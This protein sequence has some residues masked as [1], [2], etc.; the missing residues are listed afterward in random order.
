MFKPQLI[1]SLKNYDGKT[2][3][4]DLIAGI[5][6]GI[7]ALPLAIAFA[8]ASGVNPAAGLFTAIIAGFCI[9][10]FGGSTVQI[11]GP[12]GAFAVIV[13]GV[14]SE[15]GF[16]GLATATLMAGILLILLGAFKMGGLVKFIPYTIVTGFTA[17]IALTIASGQI[18]DF[19]G[20]RPDFSSPMTILG[21]QYSKMPGDFLPKIIVYAKSFGTLNI[22]TTIMAAVSLVFIFVWSKFVKK[23]PGSFIVIIGATIASFLL[24]KFFGLKTDTIGFFADGTKHFEIPSSLP[25]PHLPN[26]NIE[27]IRILFPTSASIAV[28]AA[29][30][31][32]LSA[33]VADGMTGKKHDSNTEL[34][35]QGIA[36][37][38]SPLFG[39]IPATG[40]IART[41]TNIKNGGKTP[42]AG[43]IHSI[44]LLLIL[45][46]FGKYASY[47]PMAA[48]A[49]VLINVAWNMAGFP[50]I[51]ALCHG[52][53]SDICVLAVT[54]LITVFIDLTAA[55]EVGLGFA[56]F[57][58]I[59]KM[60]DL[61]EVENKRENLISGIDSNPDIPGEHIDVPKG[62]VVYEIDG[63]LF[64]GTVRKFEVA[65]ERAG[66]AGIEYKVLILRMRNTLYLDAGG[67]RA[68]EQAKAAC[69]RKGVT[70]VI[71]GIH[72]QP[73]ILL[74][75]TGMAEK[76]GHENIHKNIM[77]AL[78]RAKE[79]LALKKE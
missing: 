58:F 10:A 71:S 56:A 5:I 23:I 22:Y 28:L 59:K 18:G 72:T 42:V 8:I 50:A 78:A 64:F 75:K 13:Y 12:T 9:S 39:G 17:G 45:L 30:E 69:D 76:L 77:S 52:Q 57:F 63:P 34:I 20:L 61:S 65:I 49:A 31:S 44:T 79:I 74:E 38:A 70:I 19:F 24:D 33:V 60:I 6:V 27:T 36:N 48:L 29:I 55:I 67:I 1:T 3:V 53:K 11:G 47:I 66:M 32:L 43:I 46:F 2:F 35:A 51:R 68:L 54:F 37:I 41:A 21:E 15:F 73:Y 14:V 7:V 26:F 4:S 62:A 25:A 40:A 16:S